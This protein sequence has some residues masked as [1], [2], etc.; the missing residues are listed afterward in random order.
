MRILYFYPENPLLPNQGNNSRANAL[1]HYFKSRSIEVD[2]VGVETSVYSYE[3]IKEMEERNLIRRGY[4]L[5]EFILRK[6][7]LKY[8]LFYSIPNKILGRI[9]HFSRIRFTH[10][11]DFNSILKSNQYDYII[12]SYAYWA[13]F[14]I[15]NPYVKNTK[16]CIDTHDF[17]TS[18]FQN[19]KGFNL[20][21]YFQKEI[22]ILNRFDKIFVISAEENYLFSQFLK[23]EVIT[24]SHIIE[25]KFSKVSSSKKYDLIY[26]ASSN[27]HNIDGANWFFKEVYPLLNKKLKILVIGKICNY[28]SDFD[29]VDKLDFVENLDDYYSDSKIAICPMLSGT[30]LKIKVV[31]ALSFG[32]PVVCNVRGVDGMVNK[33]NNGC[34]VANVPR[35]FAADIE[36]LINNEKVYSEISNYGKDYFANNNDRET[37]YNIIDAIFK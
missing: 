35:E 13:G 11:S 3:S 26:V 16:L 18:Q 24:L 22:E 36:L 14:V 20:G 31:E 27:S 4:L 34:L 29:N 2:L 6:N 10:Q 1:L 17:L 37:C 21:K 25:N 8:S 12:I 28:I 30:G 7:K 15:D 19:L 5:K 33:T 23:K 9:K 32:L